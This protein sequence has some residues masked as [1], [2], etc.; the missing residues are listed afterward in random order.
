MSGRIE[1]ERKEL[2]GIIQQILEE[3]KQQGATAAEADIG[4]GEGLTVMTRLGEV[5]K[6]EHERDKGLGMTV[7]IGNQKGN[8]SSSDFSE[9]A[10]KETG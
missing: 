3:A 6:V 9:A 2:T 10:I 7:F 5:E 4:T 1:Q 8:A